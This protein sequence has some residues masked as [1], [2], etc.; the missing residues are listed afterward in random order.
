MRKY[1]L[2]TLGLSLLAL[3]GFNTPD[4]VAEFPE[5]AITLIVPSGPGGSHDLT[6]R[7][8]TS[9]LPNYLGQAMIIKL[10][11]GAA[12][13]VGSAQAAKA[14]ADGYT[15]LYSAD[16]I[17]QLPQY[18][19]KPPYSPDDFATVAQINTQSQSLIVRT[20]SKIQNYKG[21]V[22][23]LKKAA[24]SMKYVHSGRWGPSFIVGARLAQKDAVKFNFTAFRGGGPSMRALLAGDGDFSAQAASVIASQ[25]G[26]VRVLA[27]AGPKRLFKGVPTF[28]E[29]GYPADMGVL[30][31]VVFAPKGTPADR[32]KIL[33]TAFIKLQKDKTYKRLMTRVGGNLEFLDGA[34]YE[35]L[36]PSQGKMYKGLVD[37]LTK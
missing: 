1:K 17:D 25:E 37:S 5:K 31:R 34:S 9:V 2:L 33:R 29:L 23:A 32:L 13:Q 26:K 6:G 11:P 12:G 10:V 21:L 19:T 22:S 24:G 27:S 7:V 28:I 18:T 15:L 4:A 3:L 30:R 16:L 35:K 20:D 14:P 8:F 36:R